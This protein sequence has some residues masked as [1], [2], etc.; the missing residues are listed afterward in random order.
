MNSLI[1]IILRN[2][3]FN[4]MLMKNKC[5]KCI[6]LIF[7]ILLILF[8]S[9]NCESDGREI[10]NI[11]E[12]EKDN[13]DFG[14]EMDLKKRTTYSIHS[15]IMKYY[16][17]QTEIYISIIDPRI[18]NKVSFSEEN[19][20]ENYYDS[21]E[22]ILGPTQK[23]FPVM[24]LEKFNVTHSVFKNGEI[25][26]FF[27]NNRSE[28]LTHII[29]DSDY[30]KFYLIRNIHFYNTD[31]TYNICKVCFKDKKNLKRFISDIKFY[32]VNII[33]HCYDQISISNDTLLYEYENN[34]IF[35]TREIN[36]DD[37]AKIIHQYLMTK[38][39]IILTKI[40][41]K[42]ILNQI[43]MQILENEVTSK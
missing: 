32:D 11:I 13:L 23:F 36:F 31:A 7:H 33:N 18:R 26:D 24:E 40:T 12:R 21:F 34:I 3:Y 1:L 38:N 43:L 4:S 20:K 35:A 27:Y 9:I 37:D 8:K 30:T 14:N 17:N 19:F 28:I 22:K 15:E 41:R 29:E 6:S 39:E 2:F 25:I 16:N 5:L 42:R 10:K